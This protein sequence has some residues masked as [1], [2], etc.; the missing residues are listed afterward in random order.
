MTTTTHSSSS[1]A[2]R[3]LLWLGLVVSLIV[4]GMFLA[5]ALT[6]GGDEQTGGYM[7]AIPA[8]CIAGLCAFGLSRSRS[9]D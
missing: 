2:V 7:I 3:V 5:V 8:A 6:N 4:G 9:A 1:G